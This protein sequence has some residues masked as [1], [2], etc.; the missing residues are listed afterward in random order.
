MESSL[1]VN[2]SLLTST[3]FFHFFLY[4]PLSN[5]LASHASLYW[6]CTPGTGM[7]LDM[8]NP[9]SVQAML[10]DI[11]EEKCGH[12]MPSSKLPQQTV[13]CGHISNQVILL[14]LVNFYNLGIF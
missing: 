4:T 5:V 13:H 1:P 3:L 7:P 12:L 8:E 2:D 11:F 9:D 10:A 14:Q 6:Y